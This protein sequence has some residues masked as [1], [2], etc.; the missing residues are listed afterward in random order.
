MVNPLSLETVSTAFNDWRRH[1]TSSRGR[2]PLVLQKQAIELL[3]YYSKSQVLKALHVNHS[4]L[5]RWQQQEMAATECA[6]IRLTP[7][8]PAASAQP[9][10]QV[11]LRNIN[12][13][14]LT[15]TGMTLAQIT[16][17]ATHF[18]A[19]AGESL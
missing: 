10:L 12:G 2:I 9:S 11:T 3:A 4:M 15:I 8:S 17:L 14:E 16:T 7:E 19:P 5:K 1:R 18:T 6:F 13:G